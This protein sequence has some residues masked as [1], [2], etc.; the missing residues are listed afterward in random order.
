MLDPRNPFAAPHPTGFDGLETFDPY[1]PGGVST[2]ASFYIPGCD[3][4]TSN[5][6]CFC[7]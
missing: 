2:N 4:G 3:P 1:D 7:A 6:N 5:T